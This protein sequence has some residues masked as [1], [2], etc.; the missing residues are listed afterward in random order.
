MKKTKIKSERAIEL[1]LAASK[2]L[3]DIKSGIVAPK[4]YPRPK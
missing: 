1:L 3:N 2:K 4:I